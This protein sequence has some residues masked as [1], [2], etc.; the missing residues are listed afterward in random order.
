MVVAQLPLI[1]TADALPVLMPKWKSQLDPV[2]ANLLLNGQQIN[3]V[4]LSTSDTVI[5]HNLGQVP[6]GWLLADQNTNATVFRTQPMTNSSITLQ[7]TS[8]C[9]VNLWIY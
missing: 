8:A 7:A 1:R 5:P 4:D 2:I 3:D 9:T 6:Q